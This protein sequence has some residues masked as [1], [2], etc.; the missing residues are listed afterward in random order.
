MKIEEILAQTDIGEIIKTLKVKAERKV[1]YETCAKQ[2]DPLLHDVQDKALRPDKLVKKN[3]GQ[4]D[5]QGNPIY[6]DTTEPV[7]RIS[8]PFQKIIVSRAVGFLLG[9]PV[10]FDIDYTNE[11]S[12]RS[13]LLIKMVERIWEK[14]KLDYVNKKIAR[15]LFSECE[16]AELWYL[17]NLSENDDYWGGLSE[18]KYK[19]RVK[20]L[21]ESDGDILYPFFN[22]YGDMVAF[23]RGYSVMV[24]GKKQERFDV[25]TADL[26]VKYFNAGDG[27]ALL[28]G[29]GIQ[30]PI[31]N[32]TKK[33]PVIYYKQN[34]PEWSI[35]QSMIDRFEKSLSNHAD[36]NDYSGAPIMVAKGT[37]KGF[38]SKGEQGKI[39][40]IDGQGDLKYLE[41]ENSPESIK[42]ERESLKELI[43]S[44]TQ[45]PDISFA[46]MKNLG[47]SVSGIAL[48]M[49][50]IDAHMKA[51]DKEEIFGE[52]FTRRFN[53]LMA[54]IGNVL[55]TSL[56]DEISNVN[57]KPKFTPY[58]P[59]N[60]TEVAEMVVQ[61][62][63]NGVMS[64][65]TGAEKHP[66]IDDA[67]A[68]VELLNSEKVQSLG[69]SFN[70]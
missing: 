25:F 19:L 56:V 8:V 61:A 52:M 24:D 39:I 12:E 17:D 46:Q 6:T 20:V 60:T 29:E 36:T 42:I 23:S 58:L 48:R 31:P 44:M 27:W 54:V 16:V 10:E 41:S 15:R 22:E 64:K 59:A 2:L 4:V 34:E 11:E 63:A 62:V 9:I 35:V 28:A 47:S 40:E 49:M 21:S 26:T 51:S 30:N 1:S 68:E 33:I 7:A 66:L 32:P 45:T 43:Y 57:I 37:V 14:N 38:A 69:E 50:F 70:V 53:F 65:T 5:A 18:V 3:S 55:D 13:E 67:E